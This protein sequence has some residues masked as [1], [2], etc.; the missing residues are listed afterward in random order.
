MARWT[1]LPAD[2]S[3]PAAARWVAGEEVRRTSGRTLDLVVCAAGRPGEVLGEVG[4]VV[5]RHDRGWAEV[6]YWLFPQHR[7]RGMATRAV[8]LMASWALSTL[9][10]TRLFARTHPDNPAA[11][12][13]VRRAGFTLAGTRGEGTA[14][15][16]DVWFRDLP[17][18]SGPDPTETGPGDA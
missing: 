13:V 6:G 16:T 5:V 2:V 7:G 9:P 17:P 18:R 11:A 14:E 1:G 4:L 8:H 15:A 10:L 3:V 12:A